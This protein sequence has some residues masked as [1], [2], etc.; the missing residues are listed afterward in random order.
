VSPALGTSDAQAPKEPQYLPSPFALRASHIGSPK[1][2]HDKIFDNAE[3]LRRKAR[4]KGGEGVAAAAARNSNFQ[5]PPA[6]RKSLSIDMK[7]SP[8][9]EFRPG[10]AGA[11]LSG[12][13]SRSLSRSP[14]I[15]SDSRPSSRNRL[16]AGQAHA[17]TK[18]S[19]LSQVA[20]V[21]LQPEEPTTETRN[22]EALSRV[23][24]AAMRMHGLQQRKKTNRS[25]RASV[26]PGAGTPADSPTLS[27]EA[28]AEEA[29]KDEEFK[30]IYHQ[31]FK[32]AALALVRSKT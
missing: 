7:A 10:S 26:V 28:A 13:A 4:R 20:T 6:H 21:P 24:L 3:Q 9:P 16:P 5:Q 23:V 17:E 29:A 12:P 1:R 32:G 27:D 19:T 2:K 11:A 14:S 8:F 25:R 22:K 30:L 31:T 15:S 18:R